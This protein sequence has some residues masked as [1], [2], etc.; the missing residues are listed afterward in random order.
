VIRG[1]DLTPPPPATP[2]P[3]RSCRGGRL[4]QRVAAVGALAGVSFD[5]SSD[6]SVGE[7]VGVA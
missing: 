4:A 7:L 6:L 2:E 5:G 3:V 1:A